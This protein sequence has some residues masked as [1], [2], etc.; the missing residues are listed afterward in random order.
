MTAWVEVDLG[1]GVRAG[2]TTVEAGNLSLSVGDRDAATD[3]RARLVRAVGAPLAWPV[4]VHGAVVRRV[5]R[6]GEPGLPA[7]A[8][9]AGDAVAEADALVSCGTL[10][11]AVLVADCV[12]VLLA[13]SDGSVVGAVHAGRRGVASG[14]VP[15]AVDAMADAGAER[16]G[17]RA[18]VG[19][20]VCGRCYEVPAEM[21]AEVEAL[22]PGSRSTTGWGT[23]ALDL[24]R[25]VGLQL[26][27]AG[28]TDIADLGICTVTDPRFFSHRGHR[29]AGRAAGRSAGV[30]ARVPGVS[31]L[32]DGTAG[33]A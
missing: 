8:P 29:S 12:P 14:V 4:Q 5:G 6:A 21:A 13:A 2:F 10:G 24:P 20:A 11:L 1:P 9:G 15:A 30:V 3:A 32:A 16:R 7:D 19:P 18:V 23:D 17:I 25:A 33:L 28:L 22:V 26:R 27:D 31:T